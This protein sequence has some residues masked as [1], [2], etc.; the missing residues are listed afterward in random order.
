MTARFD[1][2]AVED[3][4]AR[5]VFHFL[6]KEPYFTSSPYSV[7]Y[8]SKIFSPKQLELKGGAEDIQEYT[9]GAIIE[10]DLP[11]SEVGARG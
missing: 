7:L 2:L 8:D 11:R 3:P 6:V 4:P 9:L 10:C 5:E 1:R